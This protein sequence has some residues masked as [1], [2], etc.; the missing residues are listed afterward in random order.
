MHHSIDAHTYVAGV[1]IDTPKDLPLLLVQ[2]PLDDRDPF[3]QLDAIAGLERVQ[4]TVFPVAVAQPIDPQLRAA[5]PVRVL[6]E[7]QAGLPAVRVD[8]AARHVAHDAALG[9]DDDIALA[10]HRAVLLVGLEAGQPRLALELTG[11]ERRFAD[12]ERLRE[13]HV[14]RETGVSTG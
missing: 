1:N 7:A 11:D 6:H 10:E 13:L 4:R 2:E 12:E 14:R 9:V 3:R 8:G 5:L